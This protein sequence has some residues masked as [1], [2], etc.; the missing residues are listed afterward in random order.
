[1]IK[2]KNIL[3]EKFEMPDNEKRQ[4]KTAIKAFNN[5]KKEREV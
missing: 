1:M 2:L 3:N 4:L 5:K